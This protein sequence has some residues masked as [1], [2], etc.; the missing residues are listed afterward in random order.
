MLHLGDQK[1][2]VSKQ[3]PVWLLYHF[4]F[5][6][7]I[8]ESTFYILAGLVGASLLF[9]WLAYQAGGF[10]GIMTSRIWLAFHMALVLGI[11]GKAIGQL[12]DD[13]KKKYFGLILASLL[14]VILLGWPFLDPSIGVIGQDAT[15]QLAAGLSSFSTPDWNYTGQAFLGYP[16][17]QYLLAAIPALMLGRTE[18]ALQAGFAWPFWS[19]LLLF[20]V[21]LRSWAKTS[22]FR[23]ARWLTL[24]SVSTLFVFPYVTEYYLYFEHTLFPL[25]FLLQAIGWL[26]FFLVKPTLFHGIALAGSASLL[27]FS[28]TTG[29]AAVALLFVFLF[30]FAWRL[31]VKRDCEDTM[32]PMSLIFRHTIFGPLSLWLMAVALLFTAVLSFMFGRSASSTLRSQDMGELLRAVGKGL[33]IGF[34]NQPAAYAGYL[35]IVLWLYIVAALL[36]RLGLL[37]ALIASWTLGVIVLSQVLKGYAV[38]PPAVSFSRT[39]V[40][41]P[42]LVTAWFLLFCRWGKRLDTHPGKSSPVVRGLYRFRVPSKQLVSAILVLVILVNTGFGFFNMTRPRVQGDAAKYFDPNHLLPMRLWV[43]DLNETLDRASWDAD[44]SFCLVIKTDVVWLKNPKDYTQYFFPNAD[45]YVQNLNTDDPDTM[46]PTQKSLVYTVEIIPGTGVPSV[47]E[48]KQTQV[49]MSNGQ[50]LVITRHLSEP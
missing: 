41:V 45:V 33:S 37:H 25:C 21:S 9:E 44:T 3:R 42:V 29:L 1:I 7:M 39:L 19:G 43:S 47:G 6:K 17:R 20:F 46:D 35:V 34:L 4:V 14:I 11:L 32:N 36:F 16:N 12:I 5:I 13:V 26:L 48:Q 30:F 50:V 18:F 49:L 10:L 15:Q 8:N 23:H 28:Y 27:V 2:L 22:N 38:Y 24:A 40:T 31:R